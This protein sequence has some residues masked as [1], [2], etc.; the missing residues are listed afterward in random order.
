M[1]SYENSRLGIPRS[2][3]AAT[4]L[5]EVTEMEVESKNLDFLGGGSWSLG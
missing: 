5:T 3:A 4:G 2:G 1:N